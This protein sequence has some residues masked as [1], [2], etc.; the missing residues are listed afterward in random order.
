MCLR[1]AGRE[2]DL[3][4][5]PL[6]KH[7]QGGREK[8]RQRTRFGPVSPGLGGPSAPPD[9]GCQPGLPVTRDQMAVYISRAV[10]GGD[11]GVPPPPAT[12]SFPDVPTTHW[13]YRY[14]EYA[15]QAFIVSGYP[16]GNYQPWVVVTRDQMA[17]YVA[18]AFHLPMWDGCLRRARPGT[19]R[20]G[21]A[22]ETVPG[23]SRDSRD[24]HRSV[25]LAYPLISARTATTAA[26]ACAAL[27]PPPSPAGA[28]PPAGTA[29]PRRG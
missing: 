4:H 25:G 15:R 2:Q 11:A 18:R 29:D 12:A 27:P 22:E 24:D 5:V 10:A 19:P 7:G 8:L 21:D 20:S 26:A 16:D 9:G 28:D 23:P 3:A 6:L 1:L 13:A 17:V 14:V